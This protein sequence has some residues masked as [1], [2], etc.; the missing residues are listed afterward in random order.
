MKGENLFL[1]PPPKE[2]RYQV[3]NGKNSKKRELKRD[4]EKRWRGKQ[5]DEKSG[6]GERME[7]ISVPTEQDGEEESDDH[8]RGPY[9]RNSC[10]CNEGVKKDKWNGQGGSPLLDGDGKEEKF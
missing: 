8:D 4:I 6:Q 3:E 9:D 7:K 2:A 10:P 5:E 1:L